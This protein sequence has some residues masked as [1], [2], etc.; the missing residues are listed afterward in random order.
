M[1]VDSD[2]RFVKGIR[3]PGS[4]T[5]AL[6]P[7]LCGSDC[8]STEKGI[9][10]ALDVASVGELAIRWRWRRLRGLRSQLTSLKELPYR[11]QLAKLEELRG[12][13][14]HSIHAVEASVLQEHHR[15]ANFN[16]FAYAL[17]LVN[18]DQFFV[19]KIHGVTVNPDVLKAMLTGAPEKLSSEAAS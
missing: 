17:Q 3:L 15:R 1:S 5:F 2:G 7:F 9:V 19:A 11:A 10:A 13:Y 14:D 4:S 8:G 16:C 12:V 18:W 6:R